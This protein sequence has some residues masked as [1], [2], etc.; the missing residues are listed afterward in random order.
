MVQRKMETV[1]ALSRLRVTGN[2]P[3]T[4]LTNS[5][6][7]RVSWIGAFDKGVSKRPLCKIHAMQRIGYVLLFGWFLISEE[8][9]IK[10]DV[11]WID[12]AFITIAL[13]VFN[14]IMIWYVFLNT[15]KKLDINYIP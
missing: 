12:T 1:A 6:K 13:H 4:L 15:S 14:E 8:Q 7:R 11:P 10:Q 2:P 5:K 9:W 3:P